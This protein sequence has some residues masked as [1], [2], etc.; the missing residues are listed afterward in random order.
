MS[1]IYRSPYRFF[2]LSAF[3]ILQIKL[4]LTVSSINSEFYFPQYRYMVNRGS[5]TLLYLFSSAE[6]KNTHYRFHFNFLGLNAVLVDLS[7]LS[8]RIPSFLELTN[9]FLCLWVMLSKYILHFTVTKLY[10]YFMFYCNKHKSPRDKGKRWPIS[11]MWK[12][13]E[14]YFNKPKPMYSM[15]SSTL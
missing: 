2:K 8:S 14:P 1:L 15:A 3:Y 9:F 7:E 6:I 5:V 11:T 4:S 13:G 12:K 10:R